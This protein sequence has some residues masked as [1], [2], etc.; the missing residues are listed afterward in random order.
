VQGQ[1]IWYDGANPRVYNGDARLGPDFLRLLDAP[2]TLVVLGDLIISD[3]VTEAALREKLA[4]LAVFGDVIAPA[5]LIGAVQIVATEILGDIRA[6]DG[7][8]GSGS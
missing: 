5:E 1:A 4:G 2:A 7:P 3:G 6:S 8:D